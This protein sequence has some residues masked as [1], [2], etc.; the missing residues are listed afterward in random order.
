[1]LPGG[2]EFDGPAG[3]KAILMDRLDAFRDHLTSEM[4]TYAI[5]RGAEP[6]DRPAIRKI[7]DET[8]EN[9]DKLAAMIESIVLSGTFRT[10]RGR[11]AK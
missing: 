3:L 2:V 4:L 11:E 10:C 6:F 7:N 9:D 8:R 5:G 1:M